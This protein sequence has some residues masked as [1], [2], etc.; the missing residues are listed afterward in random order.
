MKSGDSYKNAQIHLFF[1]IDVESFVLTES[2]SIL[3]R[4]WKIATKTQITIQYSDK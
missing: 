4:L 1:D 2:G 3:T